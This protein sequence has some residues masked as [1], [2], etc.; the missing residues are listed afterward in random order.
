MVLDRS[1]SQSSS[2]LPLV[3]ALRNKFLRPIPL[4]LTG[5]GMAAIAVGIGYGHYWVQAEV[6]P[7]VG[8]GITEFLNRPVQ[9]GKL[10]G[11]SLTHL[12][13]GKTLIPA[14]PH[15]P[16]WVT[17]QGLRIGYN[18]LQYLHNRRLAL[19]ITAIE[20]EAYFEQDKTGRWLHTEV[21]QLGDDFPLQLKRLII[22]KARAAL[23]TRPPGQTL[24]PPVR[25]EVKQGHVTPGRGNQNLTFA[26]SGKLLP[27]PKRGSQL[28]LKGEFV[29][30]H[31]TLNLDVKTHQ[32]A[33]APLTTLLPLPLDLP[34]GHLDSRLAIAIQNQAVASIDGR[35][36]LH[37][38]QLKLPQ[39][40]NPL[41]QVNGRLVF[42]GQAIDVQNVQ[43][44]LGQ[45]QASAQGQIFWQEGFNLAI[46]TQPTDVNQALAALKIPAPQVPLRGQLRSQIALTG[47]L[48]DPDIQVNLRQAGDSPFQL[49]QLTLKDWQGTVAL[50]PNRIE[51][52]TLQLTPDRGG[53]IVGKG[54]ID[55]VIH[56]GQPRW[57]DF[58]LALT[59][60]QVDSRPWLP[61]D[62]SSVF[63]TTIPVS[64]RTVVTGK[65]P[66]PQSWQAE[67][68]V[69]LPLLGGTIDSQNIRYQGGDWQG[70]FQIQQLP[71]Q[72][73]A[74]DLP[75]TIAPSL[76][77]G[78]LNARVTLEGQ[79]GDLAQLTAQGTGTIPLPEGQITIPSFSLRSRQWQASIKTQDLPTHA[80]IRH[81]QIKG[82]TLNAQLVAQGHV[83]NPQSSLQA[84]GSAR[85]QKKQG[86][87][88]LSR[89]QWQPHQ[90]QGEIHAQTFPA[91]A[92]ALPH[93]TAGEINGRLA[94]QGDLNTPL[95]QWQML[96]AGQWRSPKG[97][98]TVRN[99][100]LQD[101]R[102]QAS[103]QTAG[104]DW[105]L[106]QPTQK[107]QIQGQ[108]TVT[109]QW[110]TTQPQ[111]TT[112]KGN[113]TSTQ[114]WQTVSDPISAAFHW[115]DN[116]LALNQLQSKGLLAQGTVSMPLPS[117][118][119]GVNL[120][121]QVQAMNLQV[122]A[123]QIPLTRLLATTTT[124]PVTGQLSFAGQIQGTGRAPQLQGNVAITGLQL[125]DLAFSP[126]LTGH[127]NHA[128]GGSQLS[129]QGTGEKD[130]LELALDAQR[131]PIALVFEQGATRV[132]GQ[133]Q[134]NHLSVSAQAVPLTTL[135]T[136]LPLTQTWLPSNAPALGSS[137]QSLQQQPMAG[138][139]SGEFYVD[140][141]THGIQGSR[142]IVKNP[143]WGGFRGDD[144]RA[145]FQFANGRF[146]L[147]D[148]RFRHQKNQVLL[149]GQL[150]I[151]GDRP[152]W[153][154]KV[155]LRQSRI[156]DVL[157]TLQVFDWEDLTR[158]FA[159]PIYAKAQDLYEASS[160]ELNPENLPPLAAIGADP[161]DL[162]THF[163]QLTAINT[164]Q[165]NAAA[166][167]QVQQ[168][169]FILPSL[170][171]LT[172][173]IQGTLE[174]SSDGQSPMA[175][176]FNLQGNGWQWGTYQLEALT[177]AGRWQGE[178]VALHPLELRSGD[179][180]FKLAG[181]LTPSTQR[182]SIQVEKIPLTLLQPLFNLPPRLTP[183]GNVYATFL[184][185]GT[186]NDPRF[187]GQLEVKDSRI[188]TLHLQK[189]LGSIDYHTG[190]LNLEL[191]T[192][193]NESTEPLRLK[194]SA[195]YM[196]PFATQKP[197]SD[198]FSVAL[199]IKNDSFSLLDLF[200]NQELTWL[201]GGG[202]VNLSLLGR[203]D[204]QTHEIQ[205]AYGRGNVSFQEAAFAV[206]VLPDKP[207][208]NVNGQ[209]DWDFS[210]LVASLDG[211]ISGGGIRIAGTLPLQRQ[212]PTVGQP[213]QISLTQLAV[214]I[215]QLYQGAL[216]GNLF[217]TGTAIAPQI[218]G[219]LNFSDGR[220]LLG[221]SLP[222]FAGNTQNA[223]P[224]AFNNLMLN[225]QDNIRV[226]S[227]PFLDFKATGYLALNNT[228]D[229][230][231]PQGEINLKSGLLNLFSSQ[232]RID[233]NQTS[234]K[235]Y[236]LPGRG[237][238]P[239]LD[240]S[241]VSSA[242]E[243]KR[244]VIAPN[245]ASAEINQPFTANQENLQTIRI[246]AKVSGFASEIPL[247]GQKNQKS[248]VQ[249]SSIPSRSYQE[250]V[251]L[252]GGGFINPLGQDDTQTT[253][254]LAN[255]AGSAVLGG[256]QG[257]I[258]EALGLS[259]F[260]L[261][262]TPLLDDEDRIRSNEIG[263]AAEA[264]I[265]L[266]PQFGVSVQKIINSDRPVR[267]GLQYRFNENTL[268]RGSSNFQDDSRGVVEFQQRF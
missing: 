251:S 111:L 171:E 20:P 123:K 77:N 23:V 100:E 17:L 64:G 189:T 200:T 185:N 167:N 203:I 138:D 34:A 126:R 209:I 149:S 197:D 8:K 7:L 196:L 253:V 104:V 192:V 188:D 148:G 39:L 267:W 107:G 33:A 198:Q 129:L 130:R 146:A 208:T 204:P 230:L 26:L 231:Q 91:E 47:P 9:L 223:S 211:S 99:I 170:Q 145:N 65:L 246:R 79:K 234:N 179:R 71:L 87:I 228:L 161:T 181:E 248:I 15:D 140:L 116:Q 42:R 178:T 102:F 10:T 103:L 82:G 36:Q 3:L 106:F 68:N 92:L 193:V 52:A 117:L 41:Q 261:F 232:L 242:N 215:P 258:G 108:V 80:V 241:L 156:E 163:E 256:I 125:G 207:I 1:S 35:V 262:S 142:V 95:N 115:Q 83:E 124:A 46:A 45:I 205:Q 244:N 212:L 265:D 166:A 49:D 112:V 28:D 143:R 139:L 175:A 164:A 97:Q 147:L 227:L 29:A 168:P 60:Q 114:G 199:R 172:G 48:E 61:Q 249:L 235:V 165:Q 180:H 247:D 72:A 6:A 55:S 89:F 54:H 263:I 144:L 220:I 214:D 257:R 90:F 155:A 58:Q 73:I 238:D 218:G 151:T 5:G 182:G 101:Q 160:E 222:Q 150:D 266:T 191:Q 134:Q 225:F 14:T 219:E 63:P 201:G 21:D 44:Q 226:Q 94:V 237:L 40:A 57:E 239:L 236:F 30:A 105:T 78:R 184:L 173:D 25:V 176:E 110:T 113:L 137:L 31:Q 217:V 233:G 186:R 84:A 210:Q 153:H 11:V 22:Q 131:Q 120:A 88:K 259:E 96:G 27:T 136:L 152:Q 213:L 132:I 4:V 264:G 12:E 195:P 69:T 81:S 24:N 37:Q 56:Q 187:Q 19:T 119:P 159:A 59:A 268:I 135:Q 133:R 154:G 2:G 127:V 206:K 74:N 66:D 76:K 85:W 13:F 86:T 255:L 250:I 169:G 229:D 245:P 216:Q 62:V 260:R 224:V 190:R 51:I 118:T 177:L 122:Q 174:V 162:K 70:D 202:E 109:G 93:L 43:G 75:S 121:D 128:I 158:G 67:A 157:E 141:A 50:K 183:Q 194:A 243:V 16:N 53:Q 32:L 240:L 98:L 254:G 38:T 18:P 252:L 221:K